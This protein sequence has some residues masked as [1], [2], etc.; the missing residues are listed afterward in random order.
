VTQAM[1]DTRGAHKLRF[2]TIGLFEALFKLFLFPSVAHLPGAVLPLLAQ[3]L[4]VWNFLLSA[5]V[6]RK[7][8]VAGLTRM[9]ADM[10][11]LACLVSDALI[12]GARQHCAV[13]QAQMCE[14]ARHAWPMVQA[15]TGALDH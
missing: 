7:R 8:C 5:V 11:S 14:S 3:S 9:D 4:L 6:L 15:I 10:R 2:V 1:L 12:A 13:T